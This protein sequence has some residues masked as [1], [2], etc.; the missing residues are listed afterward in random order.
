[1]RAVDAPGEMLKKSSPTYAEATVVTPAKA[2][3][4][5]WELVDCIFGLEADRDEWM[6][7]ADLNLRSL[8]QSEEDKLHAEVALAEFKSRHTAAGCGMDATTGSL[9]V[10]TT[11]VGLI[12]DVIP[13]DRVEDGAT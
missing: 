8:V 4:I 9:H 5:I 7:E 10:M 3:C 2:W 13:P 11:G 12:N 1:M 6:V